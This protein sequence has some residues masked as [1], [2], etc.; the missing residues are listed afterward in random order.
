[1]TAG[2]LRQTVRVEVPTQTAD[3]GGQPSA[4]WVE[5]C[6]VRACVDDA[7]SGEAWRGPAVRPDATETVTIRHRDDVADAGGTLRV[8]VLSQGGRVLNAVG[9]VRDARG[10]WLAIPC[11]AGGPSP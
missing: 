10:V 7:A 4:S 2:R 6:T 9:V 5:L 3:A 1:M 11:K 8:I